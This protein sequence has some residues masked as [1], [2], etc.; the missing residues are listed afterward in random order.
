M[1]KAH[2]QC[3]NNSQR[4]SL[5]RLWLILLLYHCCFFRSSR[6]RGSCELSIIAGCTHALLRSCLL[7]HLEF[8]L[9]DLSSFILL[10]PLFA[11]IPLSACRLLLW[12]YTHWV[13]SDCLLSLTQTCTVGTAHCAHVRTYSCRVNAQTHTDIQT[14][15]YKHRYVIICVQTT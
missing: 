3:L 5:T 7:V 4:Q 9:C 2:S 11:L 14:H 8:V 1:S 6:K 15:G 13:I 10:Q 12:L